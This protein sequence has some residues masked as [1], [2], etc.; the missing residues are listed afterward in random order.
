MLVYCDIGISGYRDM[1]FGTSRCIGISGYLDIGI[2]GYRDI[3]MRPVSVMLCALA[4]FFVVP[5]LFHLEPG[6]A[7]T[8][9]L[10]TEIHIESI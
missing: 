6:Q 8:L 2:S 10:Q 4:V 3:G 5:N 7:L 9:T 1:R